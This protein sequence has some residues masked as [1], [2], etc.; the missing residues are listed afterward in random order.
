MKKNVRNELLNLMKVFAILLVFNS[1][2]DPLY[3]VSYLA[4]GGALGNSLFFIISGYLLRLRKPFLPFLGKRIAR[5]YP[6]VVIVVTLRILLGKTSIANAGHFLSAYVW[7]TSFWFVGAI[8]LFDTLIYVLEKLNFRRHFLL[9]SLITGILYIAAYII[10]VDKSVWS[11]EEAGLSTPAQ[12]F[13]LIYSFYIY[14]LG[15]TLRQAPANASAAKGWKIPALAWLCFMLNIG[16]KA[17]FVAMP[18]TLRFQFMAQVFC[19]GFAYYSLLTALEFEENYLKKTAEAFRRVICEYSKMSLEM[20]LVQFGMI[21]I[22]L[23]LFFPLN[24]V[25]AFIL[26][27]VSAYVLHR[28]DQWIFGKLTTW[29]AL[30]K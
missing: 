25:S 29:I 1:H 10:I 16:I 28:I 12:W 18:Y 21:G 9:F 27:S 13:K 15:Y 30:S 2:C 17:L 7:P 5:L 11:V 14:A 8:V 4:T 3:P 24:V 19:I 20:Y 26:T 23:N 22:C 6:G